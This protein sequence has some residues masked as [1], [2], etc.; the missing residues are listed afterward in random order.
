MDARNPCILLKYVYVL[1]FTI[2]LTLYFLNSLPVIIQWAV[3]A[4][5]NM[6]N[7]NVENQKIIASL[8]QQGTVSSAALQEMGLTLHNDGNKDITVVPLDTLRNLK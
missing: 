7:N 3:L 8:T 1:S 4:V 6:C 5:R 2:L